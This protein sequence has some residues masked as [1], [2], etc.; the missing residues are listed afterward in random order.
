MT[1]IIFH[2]HPSGWH[3]LQCTRTP[4]QSGR[5]TDTYRANLLQN[6]IGQVSLS[7]MILSDKKRGFYNILK[8]WSVKKVISKTLI[9]QRYFKSAKH[10]SAINRKKHGNVSLILVFA[11]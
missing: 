8:M 5:I 9:N 4:Y 2:F 7:Q 6:Q 1:K 10:G 3:L 11:S